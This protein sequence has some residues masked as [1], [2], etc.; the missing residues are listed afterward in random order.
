MIFLRV[1]LLFCSLGV[2]PCVAKLSHITEESMH[3]SFVEG[4]GGA[5]VGK[6]EPPVERKKEISPFCFSSF[7]QPVPVSL[8]LTGLS[9]G[10]WFYGSFMGRGVT[11]FRAG[12]WVGC[13][14]TLALWVE[15]KLPSYLFQQG[16]TLFYS[17]VQT[18]IRE[19][20]QKFFVF[21]KKEL[22]HQIKQL[23]S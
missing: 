7:I 21:L 6:K 5:S 4:G 12:T 9:A 16:K 1:F 23:V 3:H 13:I 20:L 15:P 14:S 2:S 8:I 10:G 17:T 11:F 18:L 19:C 22:L